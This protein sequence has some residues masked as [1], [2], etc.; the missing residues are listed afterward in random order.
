MERKVTSGLEEFG[1]PAVQNM[2][3]AESE[4]ETWEKLLDHL[5]QTLSFSY[6]WSC[7]LSLSLSLSKE[8]ES[9]LTYPISMS[10]SFPLPHTATG[11]NR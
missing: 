8:L 11:L 9:D 4:I 1:D 10:V 5:I 2:A 7:A 6:K 3:N